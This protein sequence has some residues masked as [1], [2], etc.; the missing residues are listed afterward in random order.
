MTVA[1]RGAYPL[2][3]LMLAVGLLVAVS[4]ALGF[5]LGKLQ[6]GPATT[7]TRFE[8]ITVT[9]GASSI[10][11]GQCFETVTRPKDWPDALR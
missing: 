3:G 9:Q 1:K 6:A 8:H 2:W 11:R 10:T 5:Q 4:G 7:H